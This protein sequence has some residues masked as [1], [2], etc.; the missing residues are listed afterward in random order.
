MKTPVIVNNLGALPEI[1]AKSGGGY[2]YNNNIELTKAMDILITQPE[3]RE[4]LGEKGYKAYR[5]YWTEESH[6]RKYFDLI[7][8]ISEQKKKPMKQQMW[9]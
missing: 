2:I 6:L 4:E 5:K 7:S 9:N 3:I 1:V 8:K